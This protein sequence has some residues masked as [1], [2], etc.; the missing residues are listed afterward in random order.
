MSQAAADDSAIQ[1]HYLNSVALKRE[2]SL[3]RDVFTLGP[4]HR[5]DEFYSQQQEQERAGHKT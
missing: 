5:A 4:K 2:E 3:S 1:D